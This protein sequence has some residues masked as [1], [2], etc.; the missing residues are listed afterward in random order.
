MVTVVDMMANL[1]LLDIENESI[2][3]IGVTSEKIL[4]L[5]RDQLYHGFDSEKTRL[6]KYRD[7]DYA[8]MKRGMNPNPGLGN[9]DL[10]LT[11][12]FVSS[13]QVDA[14]SSGLE[15]KADDPNDLTGK[16]GDQIFGLDDENQQYYNQEV[17]LPELASKIEDL[18]GL[19]II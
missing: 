4:D 17:F 15:I 18:T 14:D 16:Y 10:I 1:S 3:A 12:A 7:P 13:F 2:A 11:G 5:N 6:K 19:K 9:P 8:E